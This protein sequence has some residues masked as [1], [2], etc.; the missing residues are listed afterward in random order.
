MQIFIDLTNPVVYEPSFGNPLL[1][2]GTSAG[3]E[4]S[5]LLEGRGAFVYK[6]FNTLG[7]QYFGEKDAM[8]GGHTVDMLYAGPHPQAE[9]GTDVGQPTQMSSTAA[10]SGSSGG[11]PARKGSRAAMVTHTKGPAAADAA[12]LVERLITDCGFRPVWTGPIRYARNLES[13]AEL[14]IS[15]AYVSKA[16][17]SKPFAFTVVDK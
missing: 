12:R 15:M 4:F 16:R 6:A 9:E 8:F 10:P 5:R 1:A 17:A 3:E 11:T 7:A 14:W 2:V 13:L